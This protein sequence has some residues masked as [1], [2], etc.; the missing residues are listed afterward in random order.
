MSGLTNRQLAG[1]AGAGSAA[2]LLAALTFQHF[3]Y[4]PCE[5]C[6]L[7]RWPHLAAAVLGLGIWAFGWKRGLAVL[8]LLAA[9]TAVAF[10]IFHTGVELKLWQGPSHCSGGISGMTTMS[11]ND[12]MAQL[13]AAPVVRCDEAAWSLF[14]ISMAGWNAI[15]SAVLSGIW[16]G[17]VFRRA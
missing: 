12:L 10:A 3:G 8:G 2:L 15:C 7:Q 5:L 6:I 17:S 14:G 13:Q 1:V 4:A 9:L 16:A 11:A